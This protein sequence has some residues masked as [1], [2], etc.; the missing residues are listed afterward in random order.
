MK[1]QRNAITAAAAQDSNVMDQRARAEKLI[2]ISLI[3]PQLHLSSQCFNS[4]PEG[5]LPL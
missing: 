4:I 2:V 5:K 1:E 3:D